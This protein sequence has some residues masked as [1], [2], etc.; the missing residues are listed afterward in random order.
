VDDDRLKNRVLVA[1][2]T[3]LVTATDRLAEFVAGTRLAD[4]PADVIARGRLILADCIG[5]MVA[6]AVEPEVRRLAQANG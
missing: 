1:Q 4:I 6:G 2:G 5:C 3:L